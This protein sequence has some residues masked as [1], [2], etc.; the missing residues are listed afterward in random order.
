MLR[1]RTL[2]GAHRADDE[3]YWEHF[4]DG[5]CVPEQLKPPSQD[6]SDTGRYKSTFFLI[7][8]LTFTPD[9]F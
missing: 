1:R 4:I 7:G 8:C 3:D 6:E 9:S 5:M 2:L